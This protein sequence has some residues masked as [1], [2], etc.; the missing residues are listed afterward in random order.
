MGRNFLHGL[1]RKQ[2]KSLFFHDIC[3][4][5]RKMDLTFSAFY[6]IVRLC[7]DFM[8]VCCVEDLYAFFEKF[9]RAF[10]ILGKIQSM[11]RS[12]RFVKGR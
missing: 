4:F 12:V 10:L 1:G 6:D 7:R 3:F 9:W 5:F 8:R 11:E 2:K